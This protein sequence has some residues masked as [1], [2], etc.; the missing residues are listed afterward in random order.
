MAKHPRINTPELVIL[1]RFDF[2]DERHLL[3]VLREES[4]VNE[5][6]AVDSGKSVPQIQLSTNVFGSREQLYD[7]V[8]KSFHS[9]KKTERS[10]TLYDLLMDLTPTPPKVRRKAGNFHK[11]PSK[12]ELQT[13]YALDGQQLE[14][15]KEGKPTPFHLVR[16]QQ[17][18]RTTAC[19]TGQEEI[20]SLPHSLENNVISLSATPSN[21]R[22]TKYFEWE[23][24]TVAHSSIFCKMMRKYYKIEVRTK[25]D[26]EVTDEINQDDACI[27]LLPIDYAAWSTKLKDQIQLAWIHSGKVS[28]GEFCQDSLRLKAAEDRRKKLKSMTLAESIDEILKALSTTT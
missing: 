17:D 5:D 1:P 13:E 16:L 23:I 27:I 7:A 10:G 19:K 12:Q 18:K 20:V 9:G 24:T 21:I 22:G 14:D 28:R 4:T 11:K 6:Y 15:I 25:F 3:K 2:L 26:G 8:I